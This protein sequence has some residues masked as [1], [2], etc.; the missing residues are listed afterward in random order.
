MVVLG[1]VPGSYNGPPGTPVL[2]LRDISITDADFG[3]PR[4][5]ADPWFVFNARRV[6]LANVRIAGKTINTELNA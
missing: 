3:T 1:P 6:R 2:P 5:T 4:N